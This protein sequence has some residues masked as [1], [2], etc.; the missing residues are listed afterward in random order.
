MIKNAPPE[1]HRS[2]PDPERLDRLYRRRF[3]DVRM[4]RQTSQLPQLD[5]LPAETVQAYLGALAALSAKFGIVIVT[6]SLLP[7]HPGVDGYHIAPG[8]YLFA[9]DRDERAS[10][11]VAG[12]LRDLPTKNPRHTFMCDIAG[13]SAHNRLRILR[14]L[15]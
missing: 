4:H 5:T 9:Y 10:I 1:A 15:R 7:M 2:G 11:G 13:M 12:G 14:D 8:G 6:G 3:R